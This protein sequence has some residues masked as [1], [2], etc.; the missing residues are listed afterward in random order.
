MHTYL[1]KAGALRLLIAATGASNAI[2]QA[3]E[4]YGL[5]GASARRFAPGGAA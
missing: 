3:I 1:V 5:H 4:L 2:A